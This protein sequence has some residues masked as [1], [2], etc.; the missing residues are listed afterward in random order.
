MGKK[1]TKSMLINNVNPYVKAGFYYSEQCKNYHNI[2]ILL[3]A[4]CKTQ[5]IK[6]PLGQPNRFIFYLVKSY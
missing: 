3:R 1:S 4:G 2:Y 5:K 6:S